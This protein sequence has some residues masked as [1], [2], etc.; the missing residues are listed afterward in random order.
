M[1][2][3][4]RTRARKWT[5]RSSWSRSRR[6]RT[7][8]VLPMCHTHHSTKK[9]WRL[10]LCRPFFPRSRPPDPEHVKIRPAPQHCSEYNTL[11]SGALEG[12]QKQGAGVSQRTNPIFSTTLLLTGM[13]YVREVTTVADLVISGWEGAGEGCSLDPAGGE[14]GQLGIPS[15]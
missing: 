7:T 11:F 3:I 12:F 5:R 13:Y 1:R 15:S 9:K 4:R 8:D 6:T 2:S 10:N 14:G